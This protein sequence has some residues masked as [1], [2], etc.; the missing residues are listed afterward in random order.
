LPDDKA[1]VE[2]SDALI[3]ID[4]SSRI[5]AVLK[6]FMDLFIRD[7]VNWWYDPLNVSQS[8]EF[9]NSVRIAVNNVV[10][11]F[12]GYVMAGY[13]AGRMD[14]PT[15]LTYGVANALIIHLVRACA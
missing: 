7:F 6:E 10:M 2:S 15:M 9:E 8:L 1:I 11:K 13:K 3:K 4:I 5:D 14:F 12:R